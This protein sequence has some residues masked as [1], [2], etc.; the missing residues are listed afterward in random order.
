MNFQDLGL[1]EAVLRAVLMEGYEQA[2]PIQIQAI[3]PVLEGKDVIGCAQTGQAR[4]PPLHSHYCIDWWRAVIHPRG[5]DAR[6]G[7]WFWPALANWHRR[8]EIALQPMAT[9]RPF[10]WQPFLEA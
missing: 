1:C 5:P 2:T 9:T 8:F 10:A 3:G 6:F 7:R 4:R